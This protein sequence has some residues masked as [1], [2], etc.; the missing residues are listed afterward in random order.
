LDERTERRLAELEERIERM[1][2]AVIELRI[3]E[4][5]RDEMIELLR[6]FRGNCDN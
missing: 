2:D 5:D 3:H 1:Q 4:D 6:A